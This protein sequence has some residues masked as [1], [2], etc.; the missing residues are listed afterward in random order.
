MRRRLLAA[1]SVA[2]LLISVTALTGLVAHAA[3]AVARPLGG[4]MIVTESGQLEE[5][6]ILEV[7]GQDSSS[8]QIVSRVPIPLDFRVL[9]IKAAQP[10]RYTIL[11][12]DGT[13][14]AWRHD[15]AGNPNSAGV[16]Q[17][18]LLLDGAQVRNLSSDGDRD[19]YPM[20]D[21]DQNNAMWE[22]RLSEMD[23]SDVVSIYT[24]KGYD[25]SIL[26]LEDGS[27]ES[28]GPNPD[29]LLSIPERVS[30][31]HIVSVDFCWGSGQNAGF[32]A[33]QSL[34]GTI[35]TWESLG[36]GLIS[37]YAVGAP[38][39]LAER[40]EGVLTGHQELKN[41]SSAGCVAFDSESQPMQLQADGST[42]VLDTPPLG[43][44]PLEFLTYSH[45]GTR[46]FMGH[47][48]SDIAYYDSYRRYRTFVGIS[49]Q[50]RLWIWS[51]NGEAISSPGPITEERIIAVA[52]T[53]ASAKASSSGQTFVLALLDDPT[54]V[55]DHTEGAT[56]RA[57]H[58]DFSVKPVTEARYQWYRD[59][60]LIEG[61]TD[62]SYI[63]TAADVGHEITVSVTG[64]IDPDGEIAQKFAGNYANWT[65]A[66]NDGFEE[67][68]ALGM[69]VVVGRTSAATGSIAAR[70]ADPGPSQRDGQL[71]GDEGGDAGQA[72]SQVSGDSNVH[73]GVS[74]QPPQDSRGRDH[75]R[76]RAKPQ[77]DRS[78]RDQPEPD[79]PEPD[80]S[81]HDD[82]GQGEAE[83]EEPRDE[84]TATD[85]GSP[86]SD[87]ELSAID[88]GSGQSL[89]AKT[90][91][92]ATTSGS[93]MLSRDDRMA[94]ARAERRLDPAA[95]LN[96]ASVAPTS[97]TRAP[98]VHLTVLGL[99]GV[100][101]LMCV[102]VSRRRRATRMPAL[103]AM[104]EPSAWTGQ[105]RPDHLRPYAVAP[106]Y[107]R[108]Y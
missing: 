2:A 19:K 40:T 32:I 30:E 76:E 42:S 44:D 33:A 60:E 75:R 78:E 12:E 97:V 73:P 53:G 63:L 101:V 17:L 62:Q 37:D 50:R 47:S 41:L 91:P 106:A 61:A 83:Q 43:N 84:D 77:Q 28:W 86:E 57:E 105:A 90:D 38:V 8:T 69:N 26:V 54:I 59:G 72:P 93:P 24:G 58:G 4:A 103:P 25:G 10:G 88:P 96:G 21:G 52:A 98:F 49:E 1:C 55:G 82:S 34:D 56:L 29:G 79:T 70:P 15:V 22:S 89:E 108:T 36:R 48:T 5:V 51:D 9:D 46:S 104:S 99:G 45:N 94:L 67:L 85:S 74:Q 80:D 13:L 27:I 102:V 81:V 31:A 66:Y 14:W 64:Y 87:M 11:A 6:F 107:E 3:P 20:V 39:S 65:W 16:P 92:P 100:I 7:L 18:D 68:E 35:Y 71:G 95:L 23:L